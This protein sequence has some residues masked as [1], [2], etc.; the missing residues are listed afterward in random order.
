MG[1]KLLLVTGEGIGNVIQ[2][3]PLLATLEK[4]LGVKVDLYL[5]RTNFPIPKEVLRPLKVYTDDLTEEDLEQYYGK[6][7]TIWGYH[8]TKDHP[9]LGML[10][11]LNNLK[12]QQMRTDTSEVQVYLNAAKD[13]G[14]PKDRF[15]MDV[16]KFLPCYMPDSAQK[17]EIIISDGYNRTNPHN[18]WC[19]K[20]FPNYA[21]L[22]KDHLVPKYARFVGSV[23]AKY[24]YVP[25]TID[26]T[27]LTLFD[28]IQYLLKTKLV[29]SNDS[30]IYHLACALQIPTIVLFTFTST[31][32]NYDAVF[33]KT[34]KLV[35][36]EDVGCRRICQARMLWKTCSSTQCRNIGMATIEARVSEILGG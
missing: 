27:G 34:A 9:F 25:G 16:R 24:E 14:I 3:L 8:H 36:R 13:L 26:L 21:V 28:T 5:A 12:T 18:R 10:K 23:G 20:S 17:T 6:I 32:K 30:G 15:V 1:N 2:T 11:T 22:V 29:I 31:A 7:M 35:C 33:H 19:V 4:N